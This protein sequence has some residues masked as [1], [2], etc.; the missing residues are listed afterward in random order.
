MYLQKVGSLRNLYGSITMEITNSNPRRGPISRLRE[1]LAH[2]PFNAH[3][4]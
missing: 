2:G 4:M 1:L 3:Y